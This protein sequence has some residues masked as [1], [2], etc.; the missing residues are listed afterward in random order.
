MLILVLK[1]Y[2][3]FISIKSYIILITSS[4]I[5]LGWDVINLILSNPSISFAILR[6]SANV[7]GSSMN[8]LN[9]LG[10]SNSTYSSNNLSINSHQSTNIKLIYKRP[11]VLETNETYSKLYGK[12]CGKTAKLKNLTGFTKINKIHLD[13]LENATS[14]EIESIEALLYNGVIL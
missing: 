5:S 3:N 12:P 6:S 2:F 9:S 10:S 13:G 1:I 11:K 4:E 8:S 14:S 7:I